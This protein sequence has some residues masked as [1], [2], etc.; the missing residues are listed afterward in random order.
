LTGV[1]T[2]HHQEAKTI[3]KTSKGEKGEKKEKSKNGQ[4]K[5][6]F[7]AKWYLTKKVY[8]DLTYYHKITIPGLAAFLKGEGID[9]DSAFPTSA[10]YYLIQA[11]GSL[12]GLNRGWAIVQKAKMVHQ[13][14]INF[15]KKKASTLPDC[16]DGDNNDSLLVVTGSAASGKNGS[17]NKAAEK[18]AFEGDSPDGD[19][20]WEN[21]PVT[22]NSVTPKTSFGRTTSMS[23]SQTIGRKTKRPL[24]NDADSDGE[25]VTYV[26]SNHQQGSRPAKTQKTGLV[27]NGHSIQ[28][29]HPDFAPWN[30]A[31]TLRPALPDQQTR[32]EVSA[33]HIQ[34]PGEAQENWSGMDTIVILNMF[35][36]LKRL[37]ENFMAEIDHMTLQ[38]VQDGIRTFT[39]TTGQQS[40]APEYTVN[41]EGTVV[42]NAG[43]VV[44]SIEVQKIVQMIVSAEAHYRNSEALQP[45]E[46]ELLSREELGRLNIEDYDFAR[47]ALIQRLETDVNWTISHDFHRPEIIDV[48]EKIW[49]RLDPIIDNN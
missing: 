22:L 46:D 26:Q 11:N 23:K 1:S 16:R 42:D 34:I 38:G 39:T 15:K 30:T 45:L 7:Q 20:E 12:K 40:A 48:V 31:T 4:A 3:K 32:D 33:A 49:P 8:S 9:V 14:V 19:F 28:P 13:R 10:K 24:E 47:S 21:E 41:S 44:I 27:T 35:N 29:D 25:D 2:G 5:N 18:E 43:E 36:G 6:P 37:Q 17:N